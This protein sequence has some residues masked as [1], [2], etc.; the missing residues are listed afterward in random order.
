MSYEEIIEER[1]G[2]RVKLVAME[3]AENPREDGD[4]H[5]AG[6]VTT[7]NYGR[8]ID[9]ADPAGDGRVQ[10]AWERLSQ[11]HYPREAVPMLERYIRILGGVSEYESPHDGANNLWYIVPGPKWN[12][13]MMTE[14][15]DPDRAREIIKAERDEYRA[16][17]EGEVY[18]YVVEK[19]T[20][21]Q[22]VD[23]DDDVT[24]ETWEETDDGSLWGLIGRDY[25]ESEARAALTAEIGDVND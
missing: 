12:E 21:W 18:G 19:R 14:T 22:Q 13:A 1:D 23:T 8:Y 15:F 25:A 17:C 4:Y 10:S 2:F 5:L 24:M 7:D 20:K 11:N 6:V 16:W 3:G 9:T